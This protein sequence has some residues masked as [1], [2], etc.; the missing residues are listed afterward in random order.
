VK[1]IDHETG[2]DQRQFD[3]LYVKWDQNVKEIAQQRIHEDLKQ[4]HKKVD[5]DETY[6]WVIKPF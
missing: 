3:N 2:G 5:S 6:S 4:L 1:S